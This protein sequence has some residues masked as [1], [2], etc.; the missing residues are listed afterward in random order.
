MNGTAGAIPE[1]NF[2]VS[3][4][5]AG[6]MPI[7]DKK[8]ESRQLFF[9]FWPTTGGKEMEDDIVIWLNGGPGCSSMEG[10]LQENGPISCKCIREYISRLSAA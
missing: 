6:L 5:Y 10:F 2:D 9:W 1:V 3:E 4:N 7:S 8:D